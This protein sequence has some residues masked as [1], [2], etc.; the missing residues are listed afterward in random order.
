MKIKQIQYVRDHFSGI[1]EYC[2]GEIVTTVIS[3][4][5][6]R[7]GNLHREDGP[8]VESIYGTKYWYFDGMHC[9][10]E[11]W[12]FMVE[13]IKKNRLVSTPVSKLNSK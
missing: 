5:Y 2:D 4:K 11:H 9:D 7:D 13:N 12:K 10:E 6:Y 8:A 1:V 3:V